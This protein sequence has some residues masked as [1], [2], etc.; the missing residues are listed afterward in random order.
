MRNGSERHALKQRPSR[1]QAKDG[2]RGGQ[3]YCESPAEILQMLNDTAPSSASADV[4]IRMSLNGAKTVLYCAAVLY[5][6]PR[7]VKGS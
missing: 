1:T 2:K 6:T 4:P 7:S 3:K 5:G